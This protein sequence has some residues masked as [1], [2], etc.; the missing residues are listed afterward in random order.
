M[1]QGFMIG[2]LGKDAELRSI[3][4]GATVCNFSIAVDARDITRNGRKTHWVDCALWG[5]RGVKLAEHLK[6]GKQVAVSGD[7]DLRT[8]HSERDGET[9]TNLQ[10]SISE[11]TLLSDAKSRDVAA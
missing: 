7:M 9:H 11:I 6:K 5:E 1:F 2:R 3:Q 8:W 10:L 4:N